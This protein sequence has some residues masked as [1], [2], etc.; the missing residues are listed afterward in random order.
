MRYFPSAVKTSVLT[1][2]L[3]TGSLGLQAPSATADPLKDKQKKVQGQIADAHDDL[4]HSSQAAR[5]AAQA[6]SKAKAELAAAQ[7]QLSAAVAQVNAAR[8]QD[9]AMQERLVAAEARLAT[10]TAELKAGQADLT[11]QKDAVVQVVTNLYQNGDPGLRTLGSLLSAETP[12]DLARASAM[13]DIRVQKETRSY[14]QLRAAKVLLQ[15]KKKQVA[16]AKAEVEEAKAATAAHLAQ[17]QGLEASQRAATSL[18]ATKVSSS[19]NAEAAA[20]AA[21][22]ADAAALKKLEAESARIQAKLRAQALAAGAASRA[23]AAANSGGVLNHPVSGRI[24][25]PYGYRTHP[26][27]GYYSLHDGTDFGASCN[28]PLYATADG[29]IESSYWSDVYGNRLLLNHGLV[30]GVGLVSVYNHATRYV[31]REGQR[32]KR[33]QV[34]GYVGS[35]GWSTGCHLHF[36]VLV[37]GSTVNPANWL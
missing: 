31:V 21:K 25:S 3:V 12:S 15:V 35:T 13:Q 7:A 19:K 30:K 5:K 18:V 34:I 29:T 37:N 28:S 20:V 10:A 16:E 32:V 17:V 26:I 22:A 24:T 23:P 8:A 14:D 2:A 33:G 6:V 11:V 36:T 9:Q 1:L 4:E 27:Y